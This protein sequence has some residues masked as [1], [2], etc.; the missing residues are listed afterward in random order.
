MEGWQERGKDG[1]RKGWGLEGWGAG[2][3]PVELGHDGTGGRRARGQQGPPQPSPVPSQDTEDP[4]RDNPAVA[5]QL[6]GSSSLAPLQ[7]PPFI[8]CTFQREPG[9][10]GGTGEGSGGAGEGSGRSG[11]GSEGTRGSQPPLTPRPSPG[12]GL[13]QLRCYIFQALDL[14]PGGSRTSLGG[15]PAPPA[16]APSPP[17]APG[18]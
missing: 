10:P 5:L 2:W 6:P 12:P 14:A 18:C 9:G 4:A 8:L 15:T 13:F 3:S 7:P 16:P 1:G 11:M 17:A